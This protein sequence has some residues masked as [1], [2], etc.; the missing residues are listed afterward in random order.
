MDIVTRASLKHTAIQD[1]KSK[2]EKSY[3]TMKINT[4]THTRTQ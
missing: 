3:T 4:L 2:T 1:P